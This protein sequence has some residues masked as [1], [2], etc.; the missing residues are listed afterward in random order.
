MRAN[1]TYGDG[2][3]Y[4]MPKFNYSSD[5]T[6]RLQR[7]HLPTELGDQNG[8]NGRNPKRSTNTHS[9]NP[10]SDLAAMLS[11]ITLALGLSE[12]MSTHIIFCSSK[13][14]SDYRVKDTAFTNG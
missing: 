7:H 9:A 11:A 13:A 6:R 1:R 14:S 5:L 4:S 3:A 2:S 10:R 8:G 12:S